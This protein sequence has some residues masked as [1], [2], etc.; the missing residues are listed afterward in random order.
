LDPLANVH[1]CGELLNEYRNDHDLTYAIM[2]YSMGPNKAKSYLKKGK[3]NYYVKHIYKL[4]KK[5]KEDS[6]EK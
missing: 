3:K 6:N 5:F 2:A 1:L 4:E